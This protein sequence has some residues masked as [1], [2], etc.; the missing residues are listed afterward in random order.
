[1]NYYEQ[2]NDIILDLLG[3]V[4]TKKEIKR[5]IFDKLY[6]IL[7]NIKKEIK[8]EEVIP[9]KLAG[10]LF[11]IYFSLNAEAIHTKYPD[12]IFMETANIE[13]YLDD[14]IWDSPFKEMKK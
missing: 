4:R 8:G 9:R 3:P 2:I 13:S 1:M 12:A 7:D 10:I 5:E 11:F 14:I 6:L